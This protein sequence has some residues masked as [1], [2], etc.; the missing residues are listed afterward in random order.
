M[1]SFLIHVLILVAAVGVGPGS[2]PRLVVASDAQCPIEGCGSGSPEGGLAQDGLSHA[3]VGAALGQLKFV[4][5]RGQWHDAVRF[6]ALGD[7]IGWLHDDGFTLRFERWTRPAQESGIP[8][9]EFPA[10]EIPA[11]EIPAGGAPASMERT[12]SGCV[13]RTRFASA[14]VPTFVTGAEVP[15][16]HHFFLGNDAA[17]WHSDIPGFATVCMQGVLPGIDV[18][19]RPLPDGC[20]GP[21]EYDLMLAP[22]ADLSRFE[23]ICEGVSSLHIDA[24]SRLVAR[25]PTPDG[26]SELIQD[27]PIAW[28]DT[29]QGRRPLHVHF[30]LIGEHSYGFAADDLDPELS[31]TVDPGVIWGTFLGGGATDSVRAL[32]WRPGRGIWVG[33]WAGSTDLPTTMGA[34]RVTGGADAFLARL[35]DTGSLVFASYLGGALGE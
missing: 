30:R 11:G 25:I 20:R 3:L 29:P 5:N 10:G 7:T 9:S 1:R 28:Q 13:V 16:L 21:F 22:G 6:T 26:D 31:A 14:S 32:R 12:Q 35:T 34:Y 8:G 17:R 33:G 19:F 15:G 27:A 2:V 24:S 4:P 23:A 18:L